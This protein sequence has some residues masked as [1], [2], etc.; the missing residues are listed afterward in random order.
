MASEAKQ[1]SPRAA[2]LSRVAPELPL[3]FVATN[4]L[5][6]GRSAFDVDAALGSLLAKTSQLIGR[7]VSLGF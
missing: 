6:A 5:R 2:S 1:N 3:A 4:Q 7:L